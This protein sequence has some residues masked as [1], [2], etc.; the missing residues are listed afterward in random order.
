MGETLHCLHPSLV[1][2]RGSNGASLALTKPVVVIAPVG[3]TQAPAERNREAAMH[4]SV[5]VQEP[6]TE[7]TR[8]GD[9]HLSPLDTQNSVE[10]GL[11]DS[12]TSSE[13]Y[14]FDTA[15]S[16]LSSHLSGYSSPTQSSNRLIRP[17][18]PQISF[19]S[20]SVAYQGTS[21]GSSQ[22]SRT[23]PHQIQ[24]QSARYSRGIKIGP[25]RRAITHDPSS[26]ES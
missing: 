16:K 21:G 7:L 9:Q 24:Q 6:S 8:V 26:K 25:P 18:P 1:R 5:R 22:E 12:E 11:H 2:F 3:K 19:S 17:P 15:S 13:D 23:W 14:E 4:Y 10:V 20:T